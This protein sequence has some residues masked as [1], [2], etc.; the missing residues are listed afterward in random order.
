MPVDTMDYRLGKIDLATPPGV[1]T[2][3]HATIIVAGMKNPAC[4]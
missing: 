4:W 3:V 2:S 1:L